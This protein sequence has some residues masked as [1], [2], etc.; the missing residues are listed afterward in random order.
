MFGAS[1]FQLLYLNLG[2][3]CRRKILGN[4]FGII[5]VS[6]VD[7]VVLED[8]VIFRLF[9][10]GVFYQFVFDF[11]DRGNDYF[12]KVFSGNI[13]QCF[14]QGEN[15]FNLDGIQI[16]NFLMEIFLCQDE[17]RVYQLVKLFL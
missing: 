8:N 11:R 6:V 7:F 1:V 3:Q 10:D 4:I 2:E 12:Y 15:Y 5:N 9:S 17:Y 16:N 14:I 13:I